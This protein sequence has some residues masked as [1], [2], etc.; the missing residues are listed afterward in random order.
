MASTKTYFLSDWIVISW[1]FNLTIL[2]NLSGWTVSNSE[3]ERLD[4]KTL[5]I[6]KIQ[7]PVKADIALCCIF[8]PRVRMTWQIESVSS[9]DLLQ[10]GHS[11]KVNS[12]VQVLPLEL[13]RLTHVYKRPL[14]FDYIM[15]SAFTLM[16]VF[17]CL[18]L[19]LPPPLRALLIS[20]KEEVSRFTTCHD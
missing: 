20:R 3:G 8:E 14:H 13:Y 11:G 10:S 12:M 2:D 6:I 5:Y 19:F 4:P 1:Q 18:S 15:I 17:K 9:D 7:D 16:R